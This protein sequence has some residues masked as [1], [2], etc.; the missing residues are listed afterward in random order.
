[1]KVTNSWMK[2]M[3]TMFKIRNF[4]YIE[5]KC[6]KQEI[7]MSPT[8]IQKLK[9]LFWQIFHL[10]QVHTWRSAVV[11]NFSDIFINIVQCRRWYEFWH[12]KFV[13]VCIFS[14]R[15]VQKSI[16]WSDY[17]CLPFMFLSFLKHIYLIWCLYITYF[18]CFLHLNVL[19]IFIEFYVVFLNRVMFHC[20]SIML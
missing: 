3:H 18:T 16:W 9:H 1:M 8:L 12:T 17:F 7:I 15:G 6:W 4:G 10:V 13:I 14:F 20:Y 5:S 2:C 11:L 19:N